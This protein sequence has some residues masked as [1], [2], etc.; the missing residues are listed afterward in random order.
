MKLMTI[1]AW[2]VLLATVCLFSA[3]WAG[4]PGAHDPQYATPG[5]WPEDVQK[6]AYAAQA[7]PKAPLYVWAAT[8]RGG[9]ETDPKDPANWTVNGQPATAAPGEGDDILFPTGSAIRLKE[10]T[11]LVVRHLTVE[12][13]V[14]VI[15]ALRI[16]PLGNVWIKQGAQV[17]EVANFSGPNNVFLRNDNRDWRKGGA[18]IANK[19]VF[20]KP[21][22]SSIEILGAV[23]AWDE[24]GFFCGTVIVGPDAILLPGNRSSQP[25]YPDAKLVLMSGATYHKRGNQPHESDLVVS[26]AIQAGTPERPLKSD[27]TLGLSFKTKGTEKMSKHYPAGGPNDYGL[28]MNPTASLRVYSTDTR[29]ARLVLTWNGLGSYAYQGAGDPDS[30]ERH[31]DLVLQGDIQLSGVHFDRML[32]GG[33][34]IGDASV[35][36]QSGI[37]F[38]EHNQ[39]KPPELFKVL[40]EPI[41]AKL[42]YSAAAIPK[43]ASQEGGTEFNPSENR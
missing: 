27:C 25:V 38:G 30:V 10:N 36:Q 3:A 37:S 39:G 23:L 14:R 5:L 21:V 2:T 12:T 6:T 24:M 29:K 32:T 43:P 42:V 9:E 41:V 20:N 18:G 40:E 19:I 35:S 7:W 8:G 22:G 33:I 17:D 11:N 1:P 31:V 28:M 4:E 34:H 16:R 15:K 26:G 13:K